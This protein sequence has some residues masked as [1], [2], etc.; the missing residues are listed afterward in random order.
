MTD[1][2]R[3]QSFLWNVVSDNAGDHPGGVGPQAQ[4]RPR[5]LP[6]RPR[7]RPVHRP[8]RG[9]VVGEPVPDDPD[10]AAGHGHRRPARH[11]VGDPHQR[12]AA[13]QVWQVTLANQVTT[14]T[15]TI[16]QPA[17][18]DYQV[19]QWITRATLTFDGGSPVSVK[20]G[21]R[22]ALG[23]GSGDVV[24]ASHLHD[25]ANHHRGHQP[26]RDVEGDD[27]GRLAGRAGRGGRGRGPGP[28][29]H[30][31][32]RATSSSAVGTAS[33]SHR[34]VLVMTRQRVAPIAPASDPEPI[35]AR[36]FTLPTTR[37]FTLTGTARISSSASDQTI[38]TVVGRP[39]AAQGG[40]V[41]YSS[42]RLPGDLEATASAALD[43]NP[44]TVWS[45]EMGVG[46]QRGAWIQVN[47]PQSS[48]VDHLDLVVVADGRHSVPTGLRIQA[49]DRLAADSRCPSGSRVEC[50]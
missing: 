22:V 2:N 38:D 9:H 17:P 10:H 32:A 3:K 34:L 5:H 11:G 33:Q 7:R 27:D 1:S 31:D 4:R 30:Q 24:R 49:C 25:A 47:R 28:G 18:G 29:G 12:V 23:P 43:G 37:T 45:P 40:V 15:I 21:A 26:E 6:R 8:V 19:N 46:N 36:N 14:G 16:L 44:A 39:G 42:S 50:R 35:L 13:A 20:L 48:S 41:A